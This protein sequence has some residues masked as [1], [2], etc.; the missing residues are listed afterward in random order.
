[1]EQ[2]FNLD[3]FE[4]HAYRQEHE[5]A[6]AQLLILL[7]LLNARGGDLNWGNKQGVDQS[8]LSRLISAMICLFS[9]RQLELNSAQ[10]SQLLYFHR[11]LVTIFS[12]SPLRNADAFL[13]SFNNNGPRTKDF[14]I[15]DADLIKFCLLYSSESNLSLN[16]DF[17]WEK[18]KRLTAGLC[19]GLLAS[20]IFISE[21][22]HAKR[23]HILPWI[24]ERLEQIEDLE[25]L[26]A[27]ILHDVYMHCSYADRQDKH[28]IKRAI[29]GL[30][31][32]KLD[33]WEIHTSKALPALIHGVKPVMLVVLEWFNSNHSIYRTH[34]RT[35]EAAR[36]YFKVVGIGIKAVDP[37]ARAI[38]DSFIE[39]PEGNIPSQLRF[40][41]QIAKSLEVH[42]LYTPSV[43]M[44]PLTLYLTNLRLAPLQVFALGHP[45]TT[46]SFEMDYVVV[47]EDYVG[48]PDCFS[49]E[50]LLLP[51]DGMPYRPSA[52]MD[53]IVN[54][55]TTM[56]E[57]PDV[58]KVAIA[59]TTM[60][61]NPRFLKTLVRIAKESN[62]SVLFHFFL[63]NAK[64]VVHKQVENTIKEYLGEHAVV[65][66]S[67]P[68]PVYMQMLADCDLFL[69]P[70]PFGNTNGI[71]D[72][73]A[74]GLIGV[75]KS[76]PEVHEHIDEGLFKRLTFPSWLVAKTVD[77]YI[78]AALRLIQ[79]NKERLSLRQQLTG[80][81]AVE[82]LFKG[83]PHVF[84]EKL[85]KLLKQKLK[86]EKVTG[87]GVKCS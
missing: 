9:D 81:E 2:T 16:L 38:F 61:L 78:T 87:L 77:E 56:R 24:A 5:K 74:A 34:S 6:I 60:K 66:P 40:I 44:F 26:P 51:A 79:D 64:G 72:T 53:Q 59:S 54:L 83:R 82:V 50:L 3:N 32:R 25:T 70:F 19:I 69:N 63:G 4:Y 43:G 42:V 73:V 31:R 15:K 18:N 28:D 62:R 84:G 41:T 35:I 17:L 46:L 1:M 65:H 37:V 11:W 14:R 10:I 39:L 47:E 45:A 52:A 23:K 75:C 85:L 57:N 12:V 22:S 76:G 13:N 8:L 55:S 48:D 67:Q 30:L 21:E 20:R 27:G 36:K 29:N 80:S 68:Y 58:L 49:E 7:D 71:V 33:Q 86:P